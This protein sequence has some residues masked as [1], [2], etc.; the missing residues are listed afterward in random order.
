MRAVVF[1]ATSAVGHYIVSSL[2]SRELGMS[3]TEVVVVTRREYPDFDGIAKSELDAGKIRRVA[4]PEPFEENY[5]ELIGMLTG[6]DACFVSLGA[7]GSK[8]GPDMLKKVD[9]NY[10]T[11]CGVVSKAAGIKHTS[12]LTSM[13]ADAT[14]KNLY[15]RIKGESEE[16]LKELNLSQLHLFRAGALIGR[17]CVNKEGTVVVRT[18]GMWDKL[19]NNPLGKLVLG[20]MAVKC[21]DL[22]R[23]MVHDAEFALMNEEQGCK[24]YDNAAIL[25]QCATFR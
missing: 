3:W 18:K 20:R 19:V 21:V 10:V 23:C 11:L 5:V 12:V 2:I 13:G 25:G 22:A 4:W 8:D 24:T 16:R 6:F 15:Y 7:L 17:K 9:L 1:G 14:S